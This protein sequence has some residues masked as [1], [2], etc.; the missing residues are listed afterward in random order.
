[1]LAAQ[2]GRS[3]K[4]KLRRDWESVKDNVMRKAVLAKFRAH[5]DARQ[6]LLNTGDEPIIED[7]SHD[8]YWGCGTTNTGQNRL[9]QILQEVRTQ[10]RAEQSQPTTRAQN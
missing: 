1:M 3:R 7:T 10:L 2:L 9:G 5:E 8:H 6:T 4:A